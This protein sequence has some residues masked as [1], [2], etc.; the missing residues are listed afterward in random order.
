MAHLMQRPDIKMTTALVIWSVAQGVGKNLLFECLS[1]IIGSRHATLIGQVDLARDFNSWARNKILVIGDEVIGEDRRQHADKLKGLITGT[2]IQINEK[3]QPVV[4]LEN[5]VNFVFLSNHPT[6]LFVGDDDR[7]Y[8]VWEVEAGPMSPQEADAFVKWR[9]NGGLAAL[10]HQLQTLNLSTF[11][12]K[13]RAPSTAAKRQMVNAS[14]SDFEVWAEQIVT[15]G[16]GQVLGREVATAMEIADC[17]AQSTARPKPAAKTVI[18]T[19]RR[20]RYRCVGWVAWC[21][22]SMPT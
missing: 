1:A 6:A 3:H 16:A 18:Q 20:L 22:Q 11:D 19:F 12:P 15:S 9:D 2:T 17:Y 13:A 7:R 14:R 5:L 10:M 8:F 4:E 21:V